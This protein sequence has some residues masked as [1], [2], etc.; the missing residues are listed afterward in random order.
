MHL[1]RLYVL[2]EHCGVD[3]RVVGDDRDSKLRVE[4]TARACS[5]DG[6]IQKVR[7]CACCAV[8]EEEQP[9]AAPPGR[10]RPDG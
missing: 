10:L 5:G 7:Q 4:E 9:H 2:G 3:A 8:R 1:P 6:L